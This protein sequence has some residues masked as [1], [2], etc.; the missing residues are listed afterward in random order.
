MTTVA[1][2]LAR[3][4]EDRGL[5]TMSGAGKDVFQFS[6]EDEP[7]DA[8]LIKKGGGMAAQRSHDLRRI[9][10]ETVAVIVRDR[11]FLT[12]EVRSDEIYDA[13]L[14][15]SNTASDGSVLLGAVPLGGIA[16]MGRDE[17][18]RFKWTMNFVI[19]RT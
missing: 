13:L 6:M 19:K 18:K 14:D 2:D 3:Y 7:G 17:R 5:V 8:V 4:L 9:K 11:V 12:G 16:E 15:I 1:Q 10:N